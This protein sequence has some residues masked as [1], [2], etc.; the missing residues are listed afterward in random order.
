MR[1]ESKRIAKVKDTAN[2]KKTVKLSEQLT[3]QSDIEVPWNVW[4][5]FGERSKI[6]TVAGNQ[7]SFGEDYGTQEELRYAIEWYADQ[8]GGTI[9]W[10]K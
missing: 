7:A 10:E 2:L 3:L 9:K 8:L 1:S 6:V 4:R 5:M